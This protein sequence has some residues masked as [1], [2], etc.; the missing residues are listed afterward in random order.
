MQTIGFIGFG[1]MGKS[2]ARH[3]LRAGYSLVV[4]TRTKQKA[5]DILA[6]GAVWKETV[7][8]VAK[9]AD[10]VM[11]MVGEPQDVEH[12]YFGDDGILAH[13]KR[14]TYVIDF[15]TSKPSLAV[16][17]HEAAK[18]KGIFALDAPV[19][20]GDIGARDGTLSIMVGGDKEAF[21]A[22]MPLLSHLGKN[23]VWQG[24]AGAGQHTKMCNQIAIATNMIGVCE[25]LVYA[26]KA[27]LDP[28]RVLRSIS[29][30]A[31]S[32]WSLSNLAPRM[33][34][35]DFAPGF[36]VKHFIKDMG[37]ALAEAE[38]LGLSLPGLKLAKQLYESLAERGEE[39]SGTQALYKWYKEW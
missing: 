16:R 7:K 14:G 28:E 23:I 6:E 17:I 8:D 26:E 2:M 39:Q 11:T 3:L 19:S 18:E 1:V 35:G 34:A 30:G 22:C 24:E 9:A 25:A 5:E 12:V 10:V 21:S 15:T 36:Y 38:T 13:A 4:Y 31:A 37:I 20:G 32:S 29:Q 33:L 27:G